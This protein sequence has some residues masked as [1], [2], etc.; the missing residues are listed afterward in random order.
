MSSRHLV[1]PELFPL[2]DMFPDMTVSSQTLP[3]IRASMEDMVSAMPSQDGGGYSKTVHFAAG[4]N[5]APHVQLTVF[6]PVG[7]IG[8]SPVILDIHGGGMVM[9]CAAINEARNAMFA[10]QCHC[11]VV[12]VDYR[13][14]PETTAPHNVE[15]CYAA[16]AW[17]N[18]SAALL[19]R[20]FG[21]ILVFGES[22]GA[23]LAASLA[24]MARD[25]NEYRIAAQIL[26]CPM[27]DDRTGTTAADRGPYG[28]FVWS[29]GSNEFGWKS[30]LGHS[31]GSDPISPYAVPAR[32]QNLEGLPPTFISVGALDLFLHEAMIYAGRLADAGV[33]IELHVYPGAFHGFERAEGSYVASAAMQNVLNFIKRT[34]AVSETHRDRLQLSRST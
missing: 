14:A 17:I 9:G 26:Q 6:E 16:L 33:P 8:I 28:E 4:L 24:L 31:Y 29:A 21:D 25:R 11:V 7:L 23:G 3:H 27:L 5:G 19:G 30:L 32:A 10:C 22:A 18:Q 1:D 15:D 20:S 34:I 2:L 12:S 13:L